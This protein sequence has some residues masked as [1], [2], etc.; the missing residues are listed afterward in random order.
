MRREVAIVKSTSFIAALVGATFVTGGAFAQDIAAKPASSPAE[1]ACFVGPAKLSDAE[2]QSFLGTPGAILDE[3]PT[4]GLPLSTRV[5]SLAGSD[6]ATLDPIVALL[7]SS[8]SDQVAAIGSG[9][10]RVARACAPSNPEYAATIQEKV[11]SL[12]NDGLE[13]AFEAASQEVQTAAVGGGASGNAGGAAGGGASGIGGGGTPGGG[14][15]GLDGSE[16]TQNTVETFSFTRTGRN[17]TDTTN[18]VSPN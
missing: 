5:R 17:F 11:A 12:G 13:V 7:S 10:A 14:S 15:A 9:L 18:A 4:G 6:A 8:N 1:T 2:V 3:F 16:S